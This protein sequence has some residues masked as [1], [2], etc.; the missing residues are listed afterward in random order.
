MEPDAVRSEV[1]RGDLD[2][3]RTLAVMRRGAHDPTM[4]LAPG[5][6]RRASHT[7]E[8]PATTHLLHRAGRLEVESWGP[9]ADWAAD[10]AP[11]LAGLC[12]DDT[13]FDPTLHPVVRDLHRRLPGVRIGRS[14]AVSEAVVPS[15]L[16]Q[17]VTGLEARRSFKTLVRWLGEPAP[18]PGGLTLPPTPEA[19]AATPSWT[20][21][22]AGVE[23][24][25]AETIT[26]AMHRWRRLEEAAT[27][28]MADA[29]TRLLAFPGIG[30]WTAAEVALVALGDTDAVSVGDYNLPH[31]VSWGLAGEARGDDARMLE[32]LAPWAGHRA[33]VLR[34]VVAGG[35]RAP[36]FGPRHAVRSLR[37]L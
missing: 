1:V 26:R 28:P 15:I 4:V 5:E 13:G 29:Y 31:Q 21:H 25:R 22:R 37:D 7:P 27:M 12:D 2:L 34:L 6:C 14:G 11:A 35:G 9:G 20:F 18:G 10:H 23:R 17:K 24:K 3:R 30:A 19:L 16:E 8:G 32:L 33:R 36:R